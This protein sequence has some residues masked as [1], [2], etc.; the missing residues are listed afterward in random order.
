MKEMI[1]QT[2]KGYCSPETEEGA[3]IPALLC[4]SLMNGSSEDIVDEEWQF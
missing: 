3:Y 1:E 2:K 4:D